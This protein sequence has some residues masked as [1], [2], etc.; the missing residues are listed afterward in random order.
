MSA[1]HRL[2]S[3][4]SPEKLKGLKRF[5]GLEVE[6]LE[7]EGLEVEDL[8]EVFCFLEGLEFEDG[9]FRFLRGIGVV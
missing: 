7:V 6:G 3:L 8:E 5:E 4:R 1:K 9:F 2:L